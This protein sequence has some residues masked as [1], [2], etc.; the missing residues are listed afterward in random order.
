[1]IEER[2]AEFKAKQR[3]RTLEE[4]GRDAFNAIPSLWRGATR[5]IFTDDLLQRS[6][7]ARIAAD[8]FGGNPDRVFSGA[9]FEDAKHHRVAAYKNMVSIPQQVYS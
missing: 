7:S 3:G 4:K 5:N 9:S 6:R 2:A 8:L 1:M